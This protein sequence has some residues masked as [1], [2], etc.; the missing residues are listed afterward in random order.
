MVVND[1]KVADL[2]FALARDAKLNVNIHAGISG[3]VSL[4]AVDQTLPASLSRIAKQIDLRFEL[5]GPN[6]A[7]IYRHALPQ[8]LPIDYVN[9]ARDVTGT[10]S[11]NAR[12]RP[13]RCRPPVASPQPER[14][15][16]ADRKR[17]ATE[18]W[19]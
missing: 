11:T 4:N 7:V 18:F 17:V 13:A 12:S 8:E 1:V 9:L 10:V 5:D 14:L 19:K 2:L 3:Q 15:T 16:P 6:L